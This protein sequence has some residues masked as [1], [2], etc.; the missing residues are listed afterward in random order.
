MFYIHGG[1]FMQNQSPFS[2][3]AL[4][5]KAPSEVDNTL[6]ERNTH[7]SFELPIETYTD[8]CAIFHTLYNHWH[9]E[10]EII[11]IEDGIG[12]VR[13]NRESLRVKKGDLLIVNPGVLHGIKTDLKHIL[14]FKS[15]VFDLEF[16]RGSAGDLCQERVISPLM[17]NRAEFVHQICP[18]DKNYEKIYRLFFQIHDCHRL[19]EAYYFVKLKALLYEFFHEMLVA[20]YIIPTDTEHNKNLSSIKRVI[21]YMNQHYPETLTAKDLALS[22]NF[23]EYYFMKIFRQYTGKTLIG[24][25]NDLRLEKAKTL[26]MHTQDS[27][28]EIALRTGFNNTSYFIKK[29]EQANGISP[30]KFRRNLL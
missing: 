20:N 25:L 2:T 4:A 21:D 26:L 19:K 14:Y 23:S 8:N 12:M 15:I 3:V 18:Q 27:V 30:S 7:G 11:C 5:L 29:F 6:K 9:D 1:I 28:T 17:E 24:Y 22:S 13:L 10:M 16:L